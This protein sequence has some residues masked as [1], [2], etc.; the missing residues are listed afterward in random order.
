MQKRWGPCKLLH[1]SSSTFGVKGWTVYLSMS[2]LR[3]LDLAPLPKLHLWNITLSWVSIWCLYKNTQ[4]TIVNFHR[5]GEEH[6]VGSA[7]YSLGAKSQADSI[8]R[9]SGDLGRGSF[10]RQNNMYKPITLL[11]GAPNP[12]PV[13]P[14]VQKGKLFWGT[15]R[16]WLSLSLF[17]ASTCQ[18]FTGW[19]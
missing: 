9:P 8:A 10:L 17:I 6:L 3:V 13:L 18:W 19:R 15:W 5:C 12:S 16:G 4:S 7:Q 1:S 2:G 14:N 11:I